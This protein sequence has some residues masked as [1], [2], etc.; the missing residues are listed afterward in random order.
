M[1]YDF[2]IAS[3]LPELS[4]MNDVA[5]QIDQWERRVGNSQLK[6]FNHIEHSLRMAY[7]NQKYYAML[8]GT[9]AYN[10]N[11][12]MPTLTRTEE[13]NGLVFFD[14]GV[15]NQRDFK[16]WVLTAYLRYAAIQNKLILS[17]TGSYIYYHADSKL[18]NNHRGFFYGNLS[19]ESY[20]GNFYLSA[21]VSSRYNALYAES[22]WYNEYTSSLSATYKW[23]NYQVGLMWEQPLQSNGTNSSVETTNNV[24]QKIQ[25]QRNLEAGNHIL[26][27]FSW[28]W[29]YGFKSKAQDA[30]FDNKDTKAGIL[31]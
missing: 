21:N 17:G 23:K 11:A 22:I 10:K 6:P 12:I 28:R 4:N 30:D 16:Q 14:N 7:Y 27:T 8:L 20:L 9:Y 19:V 2:N 5:Y 24:V 3:R 25:R 29:D 13:N 1:G 15:G 26:L 31:K 18:Y